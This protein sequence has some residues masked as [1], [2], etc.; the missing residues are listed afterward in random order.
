MKTI[1][2]THMASLNFEAIPLI[3]NDGDLTNLPWQ[4]NLTQQMK[5]RGQDIIFP[6]ISL[7]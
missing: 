6:P 1:L 5:H 3:V 7:L 4:N 2:F